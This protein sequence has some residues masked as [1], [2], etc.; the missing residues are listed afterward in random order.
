M[1]EYLFWWVCE[2]K[3]SGWCLSVSMY[4]LAFSG[5]AS[6]LLPGL[7]GTGEGGGH[8]LTS[9]RPSTRTTMVPVSGGTAARG[10]WHVP[11][12]KGVLFYISL[13]R[14]VDRADLRDQEA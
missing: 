14:M 3:L 4:V 6:E 8:S 5:T 7:I 1:N 11:P 2:K 9:K 12:R 13:V 10:T